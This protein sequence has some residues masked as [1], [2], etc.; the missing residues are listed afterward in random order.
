[1]QARA[2]REQQ[3]KEE[4][5]QKENEERV[6]VRACPSLLPCV[7]LL[8]TDVCVHVCMLHGRWCVMYVGCV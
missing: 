6:E 4:E 1:M 3:A 8:N 2:L 7:I 5:T